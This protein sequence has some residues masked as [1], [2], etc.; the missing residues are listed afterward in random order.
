MYALIAIKY[1]YCFFPLLLYDSLKS[2]S[3]LMVYDIGQAAFDDY[4]NFKLYVGL[5]DIG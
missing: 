1:H 5:A 4:F 3:L 2:L